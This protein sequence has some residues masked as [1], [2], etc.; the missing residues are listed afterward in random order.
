VRE[1][2]RIQGFPDSWKFDGSKTAQGRQVGN[3]VPPPLGTAIARAVAKALAGRS[4]T[5]RRRSTESRQSVVDSI[6]V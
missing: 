5:S 1:A 3:A 6:L 2:A 4:Q